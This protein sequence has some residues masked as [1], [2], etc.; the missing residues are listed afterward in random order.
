[1]TER[2]SDRRGLGR[3][4]SA[5]MADVAGDGADISVADRGVSILPIDLLVPNRDQPRRD[6]DPDQLSELARSIRDKGVLQPLIVRPNPAGAGYEIVAGERRWRAAQQA[7]LHEV[8]AIVRD[9]SDQEVLEV[10]I[11]EN[12]QRAD[13]NPVEEALAY[14]TLTDRFGHTQERIAEALGKSR[15]H[16]ANAMRLLMLPEPVLEMLRD[17]RL[18]AGHARALLGLA[19]PTAVATLAVAKNLTVRDVEALARRQKA[20]SGRVAGKPDQQKDADTAALERDLSAA[21]RMG[22]RIRHDPALTGGGTLTVAYR[23]LED[24]DALCEALSRV[25]ARA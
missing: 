5:L 4:L 21:L 24:L 20:P 19:D 25:R 15:S 18:S 2:K 16:V 22:V 23:T 8:P 3:G 6:F 12:I 11:V 13:L 14:R 1:M 10:A 7:Q 17:G 9:Y